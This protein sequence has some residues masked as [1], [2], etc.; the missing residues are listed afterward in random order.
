MI[1]LLKIGASEKSLHNE[2]DPQWRN[3]LFALIYDTPNLDWLLLTKR[4]GNVN[5][6]LREAIEIL[7][8]NVW[9]GI[10]VINQNEA[11]R[12]IPKLL[13]TPA[14]LRFLSCEPLF[15]PINLRAIGQSERITLD[16][17]SGH[18]TGWAE[19]AASWS[20]AQKKLATIASLPTILPALDWV[21]IGGESG[22][23][24]RPMQVE[25]AESIAD[26]C[27]AAGIVF[28]MKQG[29]QA[30][31]PSFRDFDSFPPSLQ[32]REWPP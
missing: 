3:D 9:L 31:W 21:I 7:P 6:M 26:Q 11:D 8:T 19:P 27:A 22:H 29:S 18:W 15:G 17:L 13:P 16:A 10:T 5:L 12:D 32:V 2:V 1:I 23:K 28:F 14:R 20:D 25:W 4:V 24:A 30:N